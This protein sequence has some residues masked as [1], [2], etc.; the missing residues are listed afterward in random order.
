MNPIQHKSP[1]FDKRESK[2]NK[3]I[4]HYT[5][6][7]SADAS[8]ERLCDAEAKVS[9]HYLIDTDGTVHQ[10]VEELDRGWHAGVSFWAEEEDINSSSI[11]I[12][13]Q[14][15]GQQHGYEDFSDTQIDSLIILMKGIKSRYKIAKQNVLAH[16]DI[17]PER[18][19]DPDYKFPWQKLAAAELVIVPNE[20][21][22]DID[23]ID[24]L[25]MIGYNI[26][27][28]VKTI[29]AFQRRYR[30]SKIDGKSD[31]QC[32]ALAMGVIMQTQRI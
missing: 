5:D 1:N 22:T 29:E 32:R 30:P 9:A 4:L 6:M 19:I 18:K 10:M 8:I 31:T 15:K 26:S 14:N 3:I 20:V 7:E 17:A 27:N 28:P 11:G 21:E 12:E 23:L 25:D 16:S 2:I 24:L 13:L